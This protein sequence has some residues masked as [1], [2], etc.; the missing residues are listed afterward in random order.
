MTQFKT[1]KDILN[2]YELILHQFDL[3]YNL[4]DTNLIKEIK[5]IIQNYLKKEIKIIP[6]DEIKITIFKKEEKENIKKCIEI[7]KEIY[8]ILI[9]KNIKFV[10]FFELLE[11]DYFY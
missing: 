8:L 11:K 4:Y 5:N 3:R 2:N 6:I 7:I 9:I 10:S 1:I